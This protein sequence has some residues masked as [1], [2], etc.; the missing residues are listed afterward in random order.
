MNQLT[1]GLDGMPKKEKKEK[2]NVVHTI[3]GNVRCDAELE[4][5]EI[6]SKVVQKGAIS[7]Q[8]L[9]E[10]LCDDC[11]KKLLDIA[12]KKLIIGGLIKII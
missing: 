12:N 11:K 5:C 1:F 10:T 4:V 2:K 9:F 8:P 6:C 7:I 3:D